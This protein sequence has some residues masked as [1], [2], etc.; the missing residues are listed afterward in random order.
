MQLEREDTHVHT[1]VLAHILL[2]LLLRVNSSSLPVTL[3]FS[4]EDNTETL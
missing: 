2:F 3:P 1:H 4:C